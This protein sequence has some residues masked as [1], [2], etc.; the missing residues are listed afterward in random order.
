MN[1]HWKN[2][3]WI[4]GHLMQRADSL[5]KTQKIEGGM[6]RGGRVC[7]GWM[8]SPTQWTW[9][10][11]SSRRQRRTGKPGAAHGVAKS[12][13]RVS[14]KTT[15]QWQKDFQYWKYSLGNQVRSLGWEVPLEKGRA[16]HSSILAWRIPWTEKPGRLQSMG[17]QRVGHDWVTNTH[18]QTFL[19]YLMS[20]LNYLN[21]SV[22]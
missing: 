18:T 16:I 3:C 8:A 19:R 14:K 2:W 6:R 7:D 17:S 12:W 4:F 22:D 13:M 21:C 5:E 10:W 1:I 9:V 11:A 15:I 20:S